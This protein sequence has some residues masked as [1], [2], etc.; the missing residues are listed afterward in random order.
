MD[1]LARALRLTDAFR[2]LGSLATADVMRILEVDRRTAMRDLQ[3]LRDAGIPI[4]PVGEGKRR[5]WVA[6]DSL[7]RAGPAV[8]NGDAIALH[9]GRQLLE[10]VE[11]TVF[12]DWYDEVRSKLEPGIP[13]RTHDLEG[14]IASRLVFLSEPYRRYS[15]SDDILDELLSAL[16]AERMLE[17]EYQSPA[18]IRAWPAVR[19]LAMVVYRRA[20]YLLVQL[21]AKGQVLRLA[22]DRIRAARRTEGTFDY[23]RD[24]DVQAELARTFGIFD[25]GRPPERVRMRFSPEVAYIVTGRVW[26]PTASVTLEPDGHALLTLRASG[27]ELVRLALEFGDKVEVLEPAW[28]RDEVAGEL[29]RAL[30]RYG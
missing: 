15:A 27:R 2:R 29:A 25:D 19:P 8:T 3:A 22:V 7:K 24:F 18:V 13:A 14:R 16:L 26:H 12:S 11:G 28:L 9:F 21:R 23:P 30:A 10:F 1:R 20:L 4:A 17:I 6:D 5:R